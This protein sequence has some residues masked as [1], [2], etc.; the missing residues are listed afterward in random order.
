MYKHGLL[1]FSL[2]REAVSKREV[3]CRPMNFSV[4]AAEKPLNG[5]LPLLNMSENR[6]KELS[7]PAVR[8]ETSLDSFL[9]FK[10]KRLRKVK[11]TLDYAGGLHYERDWIGSF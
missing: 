4:A 5:F 3:L 8:V 7:V 2:E 6:K 11:T 9:A 1:I 10:S